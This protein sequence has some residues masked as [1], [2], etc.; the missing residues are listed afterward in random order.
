M[1]ENNH[2]SEV[3]LQNAG[4]LKLHNG[5]K[6]YTNEYVLETTTEE[7]RNLTHYIPQIDLLEDDCC[8]SNLKITQEE[9]KLKPI[10]LT[11]INLNELKYAETKLNEFDQI[12]TEQ[13]EHP[14]TTS[15]TRWYTILLAVIGALVFLIICINCCTRCGCVRLLKRLCC[16]T[17]NPRTGE[18]LPPVIKNFIHCNF[19]SD[20]RQDV[21]NSSY[22]SFYYDRSNER[23]R[24]AI[25]SDP[26]SI[27]TSLQ[28]YDSKSAKGRRST[29]PI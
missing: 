7:K 22:D 6:G 14:F 9:I 21:R 3:I 1:C 19:D 5:C 18:L 24:S 8:L 28:K 10:R 20:M 12:L 17:K 23:V 2:L 29:T 25:T 16:S 4:I 13:L 15:R 26:D 11:N 27:S